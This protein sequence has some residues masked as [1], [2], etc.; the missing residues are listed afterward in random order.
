MRVVDQSFANMQFTSLFAPAR[1]PRPIDDRLNQA[2]NQVLA[3]KDTVKRMED[4]GAEVKSS[5]PE[6]LRTLVQS[7]LAK[8]KRV[9][10]QGRLSAD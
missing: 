8:W 1:T 9:V 6:Q 2:L 5:T 7:E 4:H 10:Q 3:D